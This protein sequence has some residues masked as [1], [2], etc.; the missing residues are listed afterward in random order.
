M[1]LGCYHDINIRVVWYQWAPPRCMG[2]LL[3]V[4]SRNI[5]QRFT[6]V[7]CAQSFVKYNSIEGRSLI[8]VA[9]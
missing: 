4:E 3:G 6:V 7:C 1:L 9:T 8:S 2:G 5:L